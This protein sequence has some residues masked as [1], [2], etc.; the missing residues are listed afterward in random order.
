MIILLTIFYNSYGENRVV[1][2]IWDLLKSR[3]DTIFSHVKTEW[4]YSVVRLSSQEDACNQRIL[5]KKVGQIFLI[6][7]A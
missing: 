4:Q 7:Y 5:T 6:Q 1:D 2:F 3:M